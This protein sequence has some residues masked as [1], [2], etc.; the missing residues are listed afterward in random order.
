MHDHGVQT[1]TSLFESLALGF[2]V[3]DEGAVVGRITHCR[4]LAQ[5]L[6]LLTYRLHPLVDLLS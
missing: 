6:E 1:T 3:R 5:S 2:K 4:S